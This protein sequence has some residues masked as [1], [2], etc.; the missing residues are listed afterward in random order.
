M[1]HEKVLTKAYLRPYFRTGG[2]I[3]ETNEAKVDGMF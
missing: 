2:A 1:T 3:I